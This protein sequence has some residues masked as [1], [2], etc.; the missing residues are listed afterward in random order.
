LYEDLEQ[1][2]DHL[3]KYHMN[4]LLGDFNEKLG[5]KD[6]F[7]L[8]V[9]NESIHQDSNDNGIRIVNFATSKN[10]IVKSTMFPHRKIRKYT[11]TSTYGKIDNQTNHTFVDKRWNSIVLDVRSSRVADCD[12]DHYLVVATVS[13]RLVVGKQAAQ[14]FDMDRFNLRMLNELKVRKKYRIKISNSFAALENLS[15]REDMNRAWE[16]IKENIKTSAKESQGLHEL[17]Q[18]KPWFDEEWVRF[19]DQRKQAKVQWL[20]D[21]NQSK[22]DDPDNVRHEASR[23]IRNKGRKI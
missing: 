16:N 11:W 18:L 19:L 3:P 12:T 21:P 9:G 15:D 2:V 22:V 4:I 8:R 13:E 20:Q 6:I 7:K 23:Q 5:R 17:K 10:A 14:N 1:V